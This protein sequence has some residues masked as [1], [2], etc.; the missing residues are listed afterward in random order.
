[1]KKKKFNSGLLQVEFV[2]PKCGKKFDIEEM[3]GD[4]LCLLLK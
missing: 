4:G 3:E 2:C 1:M